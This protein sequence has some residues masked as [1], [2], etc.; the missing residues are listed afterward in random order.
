MKSIIIYACLISWLI[1]ACESKSQTEAQQL[2]DAIMDSY[3]KPASK[4]GLYISARVDGR[5][6]TAV[7]LIVDPDPSGAIIVSGDDQA[8]ET[9]NF[10]VGDEMVLG[11][12]YTFS[13]S[14]PAEY[15]DAEGNFLRGTQGDRE[16]TKVDDKW[17]EGHFHFT[18]TD[19]QSG[20]TVAVTDGFFR[21][22]KPAGFSLQ[23]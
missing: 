1:C 5:E 18:A 3:R 8:G 4:D 15:H 22:E 10:H 23:Q 16:I 9:I 19:S 11:E 21:T 14:R 13:A 6:W 17:I 7:R 20:K 2:H 12:K